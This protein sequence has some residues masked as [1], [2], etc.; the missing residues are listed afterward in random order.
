MGGGD[1]PK[2]AL[3][4][5]GLLAAGVAVIF[6][7][8]LLTLGANAE[9]VSFTP[10]FVNQAT[11]STAWVTTSPASE[12]Q[13]SIL[14]TGNPDGTVTVYACPIKD[15]NTCVAVITKL[16]PTTVDTRIGTSPAFLY[17]TLTGNTVG[18]VSVWVIGK[19]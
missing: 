4:F 8:M 2:T 7:A 10:V 15:V 17:I 16:T 12:S 6:L 9:V 11:N 5:F 19:K 14:G 1:N 3:R 13:V 18:N